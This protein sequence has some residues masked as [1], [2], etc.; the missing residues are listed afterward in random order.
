MT[1]PEVQITPSSIRDSSFRLAFGV[2]EPQGTVKTFDEYIAEKNDRVLVA[3]NVISDIGILLTRLHDKGCVVGDLTAE[4]I[5]W[6]NAPVGKLT[7]KTLERCDWLY[8]DGL[9]GMNPAKDVTSL[10]RIV[11]VDVLQIMSN[12]E[13]DEKLQSL[14]YQHLYNSENATWDADDILSERLAERIT[15]IDNLSQKSREIYS[16]WN[17]KGYP[18]GYLFTYII[19]GCF[20]SDNNVNLTMKEIVLC[21]FMS[22]QNSRLPNEILKVPY[23]YTIDQDKRS[24]NEIVNRIMR[25][26]T[27]TIGNSGASSR[28]SHLASSISN[29]YSEIVGSPTEDEYIA[30]VYLSIILNYFSLRDVDIPNVTEDVFDTV[31]EMVQALDGDV[32]VFNS[33]PM[34]LDDRLASTNNVVYLEEEDVGDAEDVEEESTQNET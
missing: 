28:V 26:V 34:I 10:M 31:K 29:K 13:V 20:N 9:S 15:N 25:L 19:E 33:Y 14:E 30:A 32:L 21:D 8:R 6:N 4:D 1:S 11:F 7:L 18:D 3:V 27:K 22:E 12:E 23:L 2:D 17:R 16:R 24:N 5:V